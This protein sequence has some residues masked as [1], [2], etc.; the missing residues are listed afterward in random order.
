MDSCRSPRMGVN[1]TIA[2]R[3]NAFLVSPSPFSFWITINE[4]VWVF[5]MCTLRSPQHRVASVLRGQ[6][7]CII[8]AG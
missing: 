7:H 4:P 5:G 8:I 6:D 1:E 2:V 3:R